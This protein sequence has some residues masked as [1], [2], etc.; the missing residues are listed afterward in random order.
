MSLLL[1]EKDYE[2]MAEVKIKAK[3]LLPFSYSVE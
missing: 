2:L 1:E 3:D